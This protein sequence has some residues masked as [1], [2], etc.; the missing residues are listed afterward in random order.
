M[1]VK[2]GILTKNFVFDIFGLVALKS[3]HLR[4]ICRTLI[5][6]RIVY[7]YDKCVGHYF[8]W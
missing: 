5:V 7:I 8:M 1:Y 2:I 4:Q 6:C 3:L